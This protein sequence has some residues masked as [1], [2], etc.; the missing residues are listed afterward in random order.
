MSQV[1]WLLNNPTELLLLQLG[2][3]VVI[4]LTMKATSAIDIRLIPEPEVAGAWMLVAIGFLSSIYCSMETLRYSDVSWYMV[5]HY[6][7][8][9][10]V[11]ILDW[12]ALNRKPPTVYSILWIMFIIA[13]S[14]FWKRIR[15]GSSYPRT[16]EG[17]LWGLAWLS[18]MVVYLVFLKHVVCRFK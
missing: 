15:T 16:I 3:A 6:S 17:G 11:I 9:L 5:L 10:G 2:V 8:P 7:E 13:L 12:L 1:M 14:L 4:V 18:I